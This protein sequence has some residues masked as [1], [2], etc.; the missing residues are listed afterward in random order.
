[1]PQVA[2]KPDSS[3]HI[4]APHRLKRGLIEESTEEELKSLVNLK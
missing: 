3:R 4:Q 1:M 2:A